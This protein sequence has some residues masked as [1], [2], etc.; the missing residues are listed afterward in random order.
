M[1]AIFPES[2]NTFDPFD[3]L[4]DLVVTQ[5]DADDWYDSLSEKDR[6]FIILETIKL[7]WNFEDILPNGFGD[8]QLIWD[9]LNKN[10]KLHFNSSIDKFYSNF[11][12]PSFKHRLSIL[13]QDYKSQFQW[14]PPG[15]FYLIAERMTEYVHQLEND[16]GT[17]SVVL[18]YG[19][20]T[21]YVFLS[22]NESYMGKKLI[23]VVKSTGNAQYKTDSFSFNKETYYFAVIKVR[24][25]RTHTDSN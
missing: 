19:W 11:R 13:I 25:F 10:E 9:I 17:S 5:Q 1:N 3:P 2:E 24:L 12:E 23:Q 20:N 6:E 4:S 18:S 16:Y 15:S 21:N 22:R 14:Y 7:P 8:G